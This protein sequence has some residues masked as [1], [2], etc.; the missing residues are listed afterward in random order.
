MTLKPERK[1]NL[2]IAAVGDESLHRHWIDANSKHDL[3]LIYYGDGE[4]FASDAKFHI[5]QKGTKFHLISEILESMPELSCYS[6]IFMPDDDI[7]ITSEQIDKMFSLAAHYDFWICQPSIMGWYGLAVTLHQSDCHVRFTNYVEIMCPCFKADALARC[8]STFK[9]NKTGWGI[10]A[11]WNIVLKRP[12]N[13]L[14]IVDDIVAIHTRPVGGGD[15][16]KNQ[17]KSDKMDVALDEAKEIYEK[18]EMCDQNYE[19]L[20]RGK[21]VSQELFYKMNFSIVE[22]SRVHKSNE[23]GIDVSKRLWPPCAPVAE[24]CK[25]VRSKA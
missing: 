18:Y 25:M 5:K 19:D 20:S 3:F 6:Y 24:M 9:E 11:L 23:T 10:D 2:V 4:G 1:K 15:M 8:K 14:G 16:Y 13:K 17:T 22:Y 7:F 12:T 21:A